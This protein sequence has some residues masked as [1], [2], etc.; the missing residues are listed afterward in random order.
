M[1]SPIAVLHPQTE[2]LPPCLSRRCHDRRPL[3]DANRQ[4]ERPREEIADQGPRL[5]GA[6]RRGTCGPHINDS[7]RDIDAGIPTQERGVLVLE[8]GDQQ[9]GI[10]RVWSNVS[11]RNHDGTGIA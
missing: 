5:S 1:Y 11:S 2:M 6:L 4:N 7:V 8:P 3:H 9:A 10:H